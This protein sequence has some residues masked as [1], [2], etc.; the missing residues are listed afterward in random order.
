MRQHSAVR[1]GGFIHRLNDH[2][3]SRDA[4]F[5]ALV[6]VGL[7][8]LLFLALSPWFLLRRLVSPLAYV[9]AA[10][11]ALLLPWQFGFLVFLVA[12]AVDIFFVIFFMFDMPFETSLSSLRY[13]STIDIAASGLYVGG[14]V[15]ALVLPCVMGAIFR[16]HR[17][18]LKRASLV[19]AMVL[20]FLVCLV[21]VEANGF[22]P[23][24]PPPFESAAAQNGIT[25][26]AVAKAGKSLLVVMVE[27]MGAYSKPEERELLARRLRKAAA[28]RYDLSTGTSAHYGSTTGATSREL[29]GKW[30]TYTYYLNNGMQPCLPQQLAEAGYRTAAYHGS[31]GALF[32]RPTWYP[33]IGFQELNFREHI[34]RERPDAVDG[35]CGSVFPGLCDRQVGDIVHSDLKA[36]SGPEFA[37]WLTLNSHLPYAPMKES[38]LGCRTAE[39]A[40]AARM[41]C[42][43]TEIWLDVFDK[44][45]E[46]ASDPDMPPLD[47]LVVGDHNTPMWSRSAFGHFVNGRVDWYYLR[48]KGETA[49]AASMA[50]LT[51]PARLGAE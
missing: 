28:G 34:E 44:V 10:I 18:A 20:A 22:K 17:A 6:I 19:P 36:A 49:T 45:A 14:I 40:I 12:S 1:P 3:F 15:Y 31:Y 26:E 4:A 42:E 7:P 13:F 51:D 39:A 25:A 11:L 37:Y 33:R 41:P 2:L 43:L 48:H 16:K 35:L 23:L 29:C 27:G 5:A 46:I 21:D 32:S 8:N 38:P 9:I 50:A 30:A 24:T 47:I